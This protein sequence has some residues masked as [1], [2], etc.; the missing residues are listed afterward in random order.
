MNIKYSPYDKVFG[1]LDVNGCFSY[2]NEDSSNQR[3]MFVSPPKQAEAEN[4]RSRAINDGMSSS[5]VDMDELDRLLMEG[6][7]SNSLHS[8]ANLNPKKNKYANEESN[9][10]PNIMEDQDEE[11]SRPVKQQRSPMRKEELSHNFT[12]LDGLDD[13]EMN[14][15]PAQRN[16]Q[17]D[18]NKESVSKQIELERLSIE[19]KGKKEQAAPKDEIQ[20]EMKTSNQ[21]NT[22][23]N[24]DDEED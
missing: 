19:D 21:N 24:D 10:L 4:S 9:R 14:D 18:E 2:I 11:N 13:D 23:T 12:D 17:N 5:D 15:R 1:F 8:D 20:E 22:R 7:N 6:Q 3:I 16:A